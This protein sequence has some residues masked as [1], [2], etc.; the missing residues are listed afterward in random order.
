MSC[1]CEIE[2]ICEEGCECELD[3]CECITC[4]ADLVMDMYDSGCPCGDNCQCGNA[5]LLL[6][7][8][9]RF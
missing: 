6:M 7:R 5:Q 3:T 2:C 9:P 4:V 1:E 8:L